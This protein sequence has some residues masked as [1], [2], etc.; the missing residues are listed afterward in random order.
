MSKVGKY[1]KESVNN[2]YNIYTSDAT[3]AELKDDNMS[4]P[5]N[6]IIVSS[7]VKVTTFEDIYTPDLIEDSNTP[8]IVITDSEGEVLP[9]SYTFDPKY[10]KYDERKNMVTL[11]NDVVRLLTLC[12]SYFNTNNRPPTQPPTQYN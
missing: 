2:F 12:E 3:I 10:F 7:P 8:A 4:L 1:N 9:L 6:S 11:N 5:V